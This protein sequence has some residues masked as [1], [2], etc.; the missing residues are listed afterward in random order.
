VIKSQPAPVGVLH[1]HRL[2]IAV[3]REIT[4]DR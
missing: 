1:D 4:H 3:G 2:L